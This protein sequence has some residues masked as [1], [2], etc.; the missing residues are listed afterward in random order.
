MRQQVTIPNDIP[1]VILLG[2]KRRLLTAVQ[3]DPNPKQVRLVMENDA[4]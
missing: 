3:L 4:P 2:Q 1:R